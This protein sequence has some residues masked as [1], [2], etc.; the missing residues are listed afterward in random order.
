M[1]RHFIDD[2]PSMHYL[3]IL[4]GA[5]NGEHMLLIQTSN[6]YSLIMLLVV[7]MINCASGCTTGQCTLNG[8]NPSDNILPVKDL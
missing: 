1:S 2:I 3:G 7:P 8:G 4:H 5:Y 6:L